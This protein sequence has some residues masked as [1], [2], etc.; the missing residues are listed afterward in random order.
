ML[1]KKIIFCTALMCATAVSIEQA[2][3]KITLSECMLLKEEVYGSEGYAVDN[4]LIGASLSDWDNNIEASAAITFRDEP[5]DHIDEVNSYTATD[6]FN[7]V[8]FVEARG[9]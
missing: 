4:P 8:S 9:Y 1:N 2:E 7:V 6:E 5:I 3:D